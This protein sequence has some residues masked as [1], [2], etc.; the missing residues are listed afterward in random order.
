MI[1]VI[2]IEGNIYLIPS[3]KVVIVTDIHLQLSE[4]YNIRNVDLFYKQSALTRD[5]V[6]DQDALN[7]TVPIAAIP[8]YH[9]ACAV[10]L[11]SSDSDAEPYCVDRFSHYTFSSALT[12]G[13]TSDSESDFSSYDDAGE[14]RQSVD[15]ATASEPEFGLDD[16]GLLIAM[17]HGFRLFG[18]LSRFQI[19]VFAPETD[20]VVTWES[21]ES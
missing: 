17:P 12:L 9:N 5:M 11:L 16:L 20:N 2:D 8:S 4:R 1:N 7:G 6:L 14:D 3:H 18:T 19:P 21:D 10:R 15:E 13:P